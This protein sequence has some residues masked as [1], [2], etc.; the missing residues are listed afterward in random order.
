MRGLILDGVRQIA[1]QTDLPDPQILQPTDAVV[2]VDASGLCGSDLHPYE[3]REA[4][5]FGV[6]PGHEAVGT[7]VS[8]G[9]AVAGFASGD[10]VIVPFTTSCGTCEAC[11]RGV[12]ARC[13][14][15]ELF[16]Y[17]PADDPAAPALHGAQAELLRVPLADGTLVRVPAAIRDLEA[18]LLA[19]NFPTGWEAAERAAITSG[20][21]VAVVGL[22]AVGLSAVVAARTLGA[23]DVIGVDPVADRR[24][25]A[26][27]L[28]ART[29]E[30]DRPERGLWSVI[31]A[32]GTPAAQR[33]AFEMARP[34]G[35]LSIISVQ[36]ADRFAFS[37]VEAYDR[38]L[39]VRTGRAS[40][41][42]T[43]DQLLPQVVSGDVGVPADVIITETG[44]LA[45][46][47]DLYRRFA[48]REFVKAAFVRP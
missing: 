23:G 39:A 17:G 34:G 6:V 25:A 12:S 9:E 21:A 3:G 35:T 4:V 28:G 19:D 27:T 5:R 41:R 2:R 1:Y 7:V 37:P 32:A 33:L 8:V 46:G 44:D 11:L 10:R 24:A 20:D 43:L 42:S 16:G 26:E 31:E 47:P 45:D 22:G 48:A 18:L 13:A 14:H 36:T 40:V 38:N 30:R 29:I 15:G